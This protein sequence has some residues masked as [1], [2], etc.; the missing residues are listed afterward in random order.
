MQATALEKTTADNYERH[1]KKF[2]KF[3]T[4]ENLQWLPATA[5]TV[6]LYMAALQKSGT[7]K[8]ISLQPYLSAI[9]C[10]HKDFSFQG[11]AKGRAVTRA[12]KGMTAMQTVAAEQHNVT[13]TYT[14]TLTPQQ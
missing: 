11:A 5:A 9:N 14:P 4:E 6:Q 8:G 13:E 1:W 7:V 3:R 10:F 2:V 12:V